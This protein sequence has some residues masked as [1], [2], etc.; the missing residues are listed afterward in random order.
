L[1]SEAVGI[2]HGKIGQLVTQVSG[3]AAEEERHEEDSRCFTRWEVGQK[4]VHEVG[5]AS[6][7]EGGV[8][9]H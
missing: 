1:L 2:I 5:G 7:A 3:Q 6:I 9:V 8:V 4:G